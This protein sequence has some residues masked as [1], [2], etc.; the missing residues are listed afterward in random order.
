M[1]AD[2][3][4]IYSDKLFEPFSPKGIPFHEEKSR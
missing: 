2:D 3:G 1:Y 4:F